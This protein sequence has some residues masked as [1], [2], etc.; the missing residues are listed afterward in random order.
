MHHV[1]HSVVCITQN[2]YSTPW[3]GVDDHACGL[4]HL[5]SLQLYFQLL[6]PGGEDISAHCLTMSSWRIW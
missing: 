3:T 1:Q 4:R 6:L 2:M 5:V